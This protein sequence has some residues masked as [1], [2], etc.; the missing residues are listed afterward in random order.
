MIFAILSYKWQLYFFVFH[1]GVNS[2]K[3]D[4]SSPLVPM[5]CLNKQNEILLFLV[6]N[7]TQH[8]CFLRGSH[9][10]VAGRLNEKEANIS[11]QFICVCSSSL[12]FLIYGYLMT[13]DSVWD[14]PV[15]KMKTVQMFFEDCVVPS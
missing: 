1:K 15:K 8:F 2:I 5:E 4:K 10:L 14:L 6:T 3:A 11:E 7:V 13:F 9:P 12:I